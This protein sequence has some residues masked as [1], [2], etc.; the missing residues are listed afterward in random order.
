M[1][2]VSDRR[3]PGSLVYYKSR[4]CSIQSLQ[5]RTF[6]LSSILYFLIQFSLRLGLMSSWIVSMCKAISICSW[7]MTSAGSAVG[8]GMVT[9]EFVWI[10][11]TMK[12]WKWMIMFR[13][14]KE[15]T[16]GMWINNKLEFILNLF[17]NDHPIFSLLRIEIWFLF[18]F[19]NSF[20]SFRSYEF[21]LFIC[22]QFHSCLAVLQW[23]NNT[24]RCALVPLVWM[25]RS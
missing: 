23:T 3:A 12:Q 9:I 6:N 11:D 20:F 1:N 17:S 25:D 16:N 22:I 2:F 14:E 21:N 18:S 19:S 8:S 10:G 4:D 7:E 5:Q 24:N 15:K 13:I